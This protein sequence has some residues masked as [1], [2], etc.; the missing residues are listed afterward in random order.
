[1]DSDTIQHQK[2]NQENKFKYN[3][4]NYIFIMGNSSNKPKRLTPDEMRD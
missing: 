1:M 3:T 2:L 4:F